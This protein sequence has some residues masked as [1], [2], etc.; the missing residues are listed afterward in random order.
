LAILAGLLF[1]ASDKKATALIW[2]MY[3]GAMKAITK[4]FIDIDPI[5]IIEN[6]I[7]SLQEN[8]SK[9]NKQLSNLK[10]QLS[11]LKNVI[12]SNEEN[13]KNN[14]KMASKAK[15]TGN[16]NIVVLQTRKAGRLQQSN[17]TLSTLYTK[18]EVLYR[19]LSKMYEN[20]EIVLEDT[21]DEVKVRKT[22]YKAIKTGYSA[23]RS[24][25]SILKGDP[26]KKLVFDMTMERLADD[27][28]QKVGEMERFMDIS[29]SFMDS[30]DLQN[31]VYEDDG[32]KMLE[33]WETESG[34]IMLL[35][36][37]TKE[38]L[39]AQANDPKDKLTL[40]EKKSKK[41]YVN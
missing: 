24:A 28:G 14:I 12:D 27:I 30:I 39:I 1:I 41:K 34:K 6:Y 9:M 35:G 25:M 2:Y 17:M 3:R 16:N 10:G 36:E 22:E 4:I 40:D 19:V 7:V 26:D 38:T 15:E 18:M 5:S 23:F 29:K 13:R 37:D 33:Q 11:N 20:G 32:L 31:G 21:E 8:L